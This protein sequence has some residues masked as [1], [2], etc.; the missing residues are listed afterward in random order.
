MLPLPAANPKII[1]EGLP[2]MLLHSSKDSLSVAA[3][4]SAA[5]VALFNLGCSD[6]FLLVNFVCLRFIALRI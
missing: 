1:P 6:W 2:L 3:A 4:A 5:G